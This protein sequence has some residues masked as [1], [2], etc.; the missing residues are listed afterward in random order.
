[1][2]I[3]LIF[4]VVILVVII[5]L[6]L[7]HK[8]GK[9]ETP[10]S[11]TKTID[12]TAGPQN[13]KL[14]A[15]YQVQPTWGAPNALSNCN[16]YT[17]IGGQYTPAVPSYQKIN[18]GSRD[19]Y[20]NKAVG[21]CIDPDQ[22]F[23]YSFYHEC[24]GVGGAA[25]AGCIASV[26]TYY[27]GTG[28]KAGDFLPINA[29]EGATGNILNSPIYG[30]CIPAG[31]DPSN[32]YCPGSVGVII[33]NFKPQPQYN[34]SGASGNSCILG[35]YGQT[36]G[37]T[38]FGGIGYY[39][40]ANTP[41][42]L[43]EPG[44]IFRTTRYSVSE[45]GVLTQDNKGN[46]ASITHRYTG[47]YLAPLFNVGFATN[48][49]KGIYYYDFKNPVID[50]TPWTDASGS[51]GI[52]SM[53][54]VLVDPQYDLDRNGVYW[55][56][57]DQ[58]L[59]SAFQNASITNT[60]T[61]QQAGI[62]PNQTNF[63]KLYPKAP[64]TPAYY[65]LLAQA[66]STGTGSG[67]P[68][69]DLYAKGTQPNTWF[70]AAANPEQNAS[71]PNLD[72]NIAPQQIIYV[73]DFRLIPRNKNDP[74]RLWSYLINNFSINIDNTGK[75]FL[76][77]YRTTMKVDVWFGGAVDPSD[78]NN[79]FTEFLG[80]VMAANPDSPPTD[81]Q[82]I[83]YMNYTTEILKPVGNTYI[84]GVDVVK[85]FPPNPNN[86]GTLNTIEEIGLGYIA[87]RLLWFIGGLLL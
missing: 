9:F 62:L 3:V 76:T 20:V 86:A 39:D 64:T 56:F 45:S 19:W 38:S 23:A 75:P 55:L 70:G 17:F 11:P 68:P 59:N 72:A 10:I 50:Y 73:P 4:L 74:S 33:P 30:Q 24:V 15:Q 8:S 21:N 57:K 1:M 78:S 83:D 25:G 42:D 13:T 12:D 82:F 81:T 71:V 16:T 53:P 6:I 5:V 85:T 28:Y 48:G 2:N 26:D 22:L 34:S 47:F 51:T 54:L 63:S 35:L 67:G 40:V 58:T 7:V 41:C 44:Q 52:A 14:M 87:F 77:P 36:G 49:Q 37:Y 29:I 43:S 18:N 69:P 84:P 66:G 27:G 80:A 65:T 31:A 60:T 79:Y 61:Y 32:L 46:L